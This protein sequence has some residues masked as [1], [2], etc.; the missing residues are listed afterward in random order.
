VLPSS[1]RLAEAAVADERLK[2]L[3]FTGSAA[4]GWDLKG[5]AGK[6]RVILELG[7]NAACIIDA[8]ADLAY[9]ARR[10]AI[11]AFAHAGQVCIAVQRLLVH[12]EIY[13]SFQA[14][15]LQTIEA[16]I[17]AGDPAREETVI[18]PMIDAEASV[19]VRQWVQEAK[20]GGAKVVAGNPGA[21]NLIP[22]MVLTGV[23]REMKLWNQEVFGPVVVLTPFDDFAQALALANDSDYGLQAGVFTPHLAHMWQ[24][25]ETLEVGGVIINDAPVFRL[26]HMPYGGTKASG[27][28][29]EGVRYAMEELTDLRLLALKV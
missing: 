13:E 2:V 26:D 9:A 18:G 7:G 10:A 15:F 3:S 1:S 14:I 12:R 23:T 4:V 19:R 5:K 22:A 16:E 21:G 25:F 20:D 24:A 27:L 28:G 11:G 17:P 6:K 29:R 8:G